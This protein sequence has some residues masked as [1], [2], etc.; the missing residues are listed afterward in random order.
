[1]LNKHWTD[2]LTRENKLLFTM[3]LETS[4]APTT[5][6]G[7]MIHIMDFKQTVQIVGLWWITTATN[8]QDATWEYVSCVNST[9]EEFSDYGLL[10]II[11]HSN[12][13]LNILLFHYV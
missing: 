8:V 9:E 7:L 2:N 1:M 12:N 10:I 11:I 4:S 5:L 3:P 6:V 13:N